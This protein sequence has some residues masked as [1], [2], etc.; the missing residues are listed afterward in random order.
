MP[1]RRRLGPWR[2]SVSVRGGGLHLPVHGMVSGRSPGVGMGREAM[3]VLGHQGAAT[4]D[5]VWA[6][7]IPWSEVEALSVRIGPHFARLEP[8]E[9]AVAYMLGLLEIGRAH[10]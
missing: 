10:V 3:A 7:P 1:I 8:R 2:Y 6:R 9:R 5:S 4:P